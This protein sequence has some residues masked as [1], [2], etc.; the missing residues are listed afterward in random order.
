M[1]FENLVKRRRA[2][3]ALEPV[4]IT[5]ELI[6][7]TALIAQLAPSCSN[8]Q[9]WRFIFIYEKELLTRVKDETLTN[10]N[11]WAKAA[12][13]IIA[14]FSKSDL[15]CIIKNRQYFL[16][17]TG[18][19]TALMILYLTE[20]GL[21]A[22]PIAGFF[23][24]KVKQ[25]LDIPEEMLLITLIIVGKKSNIIPDFFKDHQ[26]KNEAERP[27]RKLLHEFIYYNKYNEN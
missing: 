23:P 25:L 27:K 5:R 17:D 9:P 16:F 4:E 10:G 8:N 1:N 26:R 11:T 12:S 6:E 2:Y 18:M 13:L 21:V 15:D 14:V 20:R 24:E 22:H 3:R 7:E 19:A